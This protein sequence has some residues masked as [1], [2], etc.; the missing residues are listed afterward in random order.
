MRERNT[1][2]QHSCGVFV[3]EKSGPEGEKV[4][5]CAPIAGPSSLNESACR[6]DQQNIP[7]LRCPHSESSG[8]AHPGWRHRELEKNSCWAIEEVSFR[9]QLLIRSKSC[10]KQPKKEKGDWQGKVSMVDCVLIYPPEPAGSTV[11]AQGSG[12]SCSLLPA[13][14]SSCCGRSSVARTHRAD[15]QHPVMG[16]MSF[17][18]ASG[19]FPGFKDLL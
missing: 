12:F 1:D 5:I 13:R 7:G 18:T 3:T 8:R 11:S 19:W 4:W 16:V 14:S 15:H 9:F 10:V 6:V 2:V 17:A